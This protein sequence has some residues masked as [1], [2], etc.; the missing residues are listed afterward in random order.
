MTP[1]TTST[2]PQTGDLVAVAQ[3]A[4]AFTT[5]LTAA[6]AAGLV[7]TLK[8]AGPFTVFAPTDDAFAQLPAG[9]VDALLKDLPRL[10]SVLL[11][12]V[13]PGRLMAE[14]VVKLKTVTTAQGQTAAIDTTDGARIGDAK[15]VQT[16][17]LASNG[18]IH[19]IDRV[20]LPR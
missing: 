2:A 9:T 20:I 1:T 12:H 6:R 17:I 7:D 8:G 11:Y 5:L 16:D 10:K 15:I 3:Q 18:V 14:D 13:V 4:G 19:I